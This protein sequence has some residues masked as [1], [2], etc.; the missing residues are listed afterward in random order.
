VKTRQKRLSGLIVF[1]IVPPFQTSAWL[2][3]NVFE[4]DFYSRVTH[5]KTAKRAILSSES[6]SFYVF[7]LV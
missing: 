4:L 7:F 1:M 3:G 2:I 6:L 5:T